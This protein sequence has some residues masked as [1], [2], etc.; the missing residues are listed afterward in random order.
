MVAYL[1]RGGAYAAASPPPDGGQGGWLVSWLIPL[2]P[3]TVDELQVWA[4]CVVVAAGV[5]GGLGA[6]RLTTQGKK[7]RPGFDGALS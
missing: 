2:L 4:V 5:L 6:H 7:Q 3:G 1:M